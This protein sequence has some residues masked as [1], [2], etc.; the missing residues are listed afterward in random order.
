MRF[1]G[2]DIKTKLRE[3]MEEVVNYGKSKKHRTNRI[4]RS[5]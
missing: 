3:C 5:I 4:S 1:W 2:S